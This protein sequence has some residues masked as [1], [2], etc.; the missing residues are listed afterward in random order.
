MYCANRVVSLVFSDNGNYM[1]VGENDGPTRAAITLKIYN[2]LGICV[3]MFPIL[4]L[5]L[6]N[7]VYQ[8]FYKGYLPHV[9]YKKVIGNTRAA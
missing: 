9:S 5:L 1:I 4:F 8:H 3:D 2:H 6:T 7:T